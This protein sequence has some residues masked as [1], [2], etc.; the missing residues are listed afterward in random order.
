[1]TLSRRSFLKGGIS[2]AALALLP[3]KLPEVEAVASAVPEVD[4]TISSDV[5]QAEAEIR[6]INAA[7]DRETESLFVYDAERTLLA[8]SSHWSMD[9]QHDW[10]SYRERGD[11]FPT[12]IPRLTTF[13]LSFEVLDV[14]QRLEWGTVYV[15][16]MTPNSGTRF[17]AEMRITEWR[18]EFYI[19]GWG[20]PH[21]ADR[22]VTTIEAHLFNMEVS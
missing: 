18:D 13:M 19:G 8:T 17:Q 12:R 20:D 1:M 5:S 16:E 9:V 10:L 22:R 6:Q 11:R 7:L 3:I 21:M 15:V 2:A 4:V 14:D